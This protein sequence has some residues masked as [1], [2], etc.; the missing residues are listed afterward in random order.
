VTSRWTLFGLSS[1]RSRIFPPSSR[2][3]LYRRHHS[4]CARP[5]SGRTRRAAA[6]LGLVAFASAFAANH[7]ARAEGIRGYAQ[8]A[9]DLGFVSGVRT[10]GSAVAP[11]FH[12]EFGAGPTALPVTLG[13]SGGI[14]FLDY[15]SWNDGTSISFRDDGVA[16]MPHSGSY[17]LEL[18]HIELVMRVQ[19]D[20]ERVR[21]FAS[22]SIGYAG[23]Y[24]NQT[25]GNYEGDTSLDGALLR[26]V[27]LG[28][29]FEPSRRKKGDKGFI[30]LTVGVRGW[31]TGQLRYDYP[32]VPS[33]SLRV[34]SPFIALSIAGWS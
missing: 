5:N 3:R 8:V 12:L 14:Y 34:I 9:G 31:E 27:S 4:G 32:D 16:V 17:S 1:A 28:I 11:G 25:D 21:P 29:D 23:A 13:V 24:F 33:G 30:V 10:Q 26:G 6:L 22:A 2:S 15:G 20:W 19:P 18:R 7:D